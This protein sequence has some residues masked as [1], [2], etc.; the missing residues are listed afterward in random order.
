MLFPFVTVIVIVFDALMPWSSVTVSVTAY[1]PASLKRCDGFGS[2]L[3][4]PSM[5]SQ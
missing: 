5:K 4:L 3:V 1:V 2:V